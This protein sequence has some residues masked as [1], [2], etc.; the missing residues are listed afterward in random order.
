MADTKTVLLE[1]SLSEKNKI[2]A[3]E[4]SVTAD[5]YETLIGNVLADKIRYGLFYN[6]ADVQPMKQPVGYVFAKKR[7]AATK[8]LKIVTSDKIEVETFSET[9]KITQEAYEDLLRVSTYNG[10]DD[11]TIFEEFVKSLAGYAEVT[12]FLADVKAAAKAVT[13]LTLD[14]EA[15]SNGETNIF[16]IHKY[17]NEQVVK[18]NS[19]NFRTYD[20]FCILPSKNIGGILGLGTTYSKLSTQSEDA[21]AHDYYLTTIN[22]VSYYLNP[23]ATETFAIVGLYSSKEKFASAL[24]YCPFSVLTSCADVPDTGEKSLTVKIRSALVIN[25]LH[26]A[27]SDTPLLCKFE[28]K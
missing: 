14:A 21:R 4:E 18:M 24:V 27:A 6:I 20:A 8:E 3:L 7:D 22:N 12:K 11:T 16:V 15:S 19:D 23:D 25:P 13:D 9:A 2:N 5:Y 26:D 17:V 28:I 10:A 1:N